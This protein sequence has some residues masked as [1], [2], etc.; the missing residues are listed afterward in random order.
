ML[1]GKTAVVTGS[2]SGIGLSEKQPSLE[3]ATPEQIRDV[4]VFLCSDAASQI[5]AS[6]CRSMADGPH[7]RIFGFTR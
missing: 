4:A 2:T 1:K 5:G 6:P 3:F 7:N